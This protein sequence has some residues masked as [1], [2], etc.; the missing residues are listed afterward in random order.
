MKQF[1]ALCLPLVATACLAT[2][3][4]HETPRELLAVS[5][6]L[7]ELY[8]AF[9]FEA[10]GDAD[11]EAMRSLFLPGAAFVLPYEGEPE[12]RIVDLETFMAEFRAWIA[13]SPDAD[14]GFVERI[15]AHRVDHFGR[16]AHAWVLFEAEVPARAEPNERGIDSIQLVSSP[17]GWRIV[18]FTTHYESES[19]RL[20]ADFLVRHAAPRADPAGR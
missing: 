13:T 1:A 12:P 19:T 5:D 15:V 3:P 17:A 6:T 18:S 4:P 10:G 8:R 9:S 14:D 2:P 16:I 20:P 7:E 11:W